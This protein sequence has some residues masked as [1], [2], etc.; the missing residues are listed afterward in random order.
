MAD[1]GER[2]GRESGWG[3]WECALCGG[4]HHRATERCPIKQRAEGETS[5]RRGGG[6]PHNHYDDP[7]Y[8]ARL[9]EAQREAW[10]R[11]REKYGPRGRKP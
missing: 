5:P 7:S 8:R 9:Q 6:G 1:A 4:W 2:T 11:R 10:K 3:A